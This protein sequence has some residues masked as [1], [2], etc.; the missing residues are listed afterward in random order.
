MT[1]RISSLIILLLI[2]VKVSCAESFGLRFYAHE[3]RLDQRTGLNLNPD[4]P[5]KIKSNFNL[6]FELAFMQDKRDYFGYILRVIADDSLNYDLIYD[7]HKKSISLI[8]GKT[9]KVVSVPLKIKDLAPYKKIVIG[10]NKDQGII[11]LIIDGEQYT[12]NSETL[13][14]NHRWKFLFGINHS[15]KFKTTDLPSMQIRNISLNV[16]GQKKHEWLLNNQTGNWIKDEVGNYDAYVENPDWL[17]D[18]HDTWVLEKEFSFD[19]YTPFVQKGNSDTVFFLSNNTLYTYFLPEHRF[20]NTESLK[21]DI[22]LAQGMQLQYNYVED[23]ILQYSVDNKIVTS[24]SVK[25]LQ[26]SAVINESER[27]TAFWHHNKFFNPNDTTL[28]TLGGYGYLTYKNLIY[29]VNLNNGNWNVNS[30]EKTE[31]MPHYLSALGAN[32]TKDTLYIL[33]GYGSLTGD[34]KINPGYIYDLVQ[35]IPESKKV[36]KVFTIDNSK[37]ESFCLSNSMI[38]DHE[39]SDYYALAY[40]KYE[41]ENYLKLIKGSLDD[42]NIVIDDKSIPFNFHDIMSYVDLIYSPLQRKLYAFILFYNDNGKTNIKVYSISFHPALQPPAEEI[43]RT[44]NNVYL[45]I[46]AITLF[47]LIFAGLIFIFYRRKRNSKNQKDIP[48]HEG[49]VVN[50]NEGASIHEK[51]DER[52]QVNNP[53][54]PETSEKEIII[55]KKNYS[56]SFF[57]GFQVITKNGENITK[58]FTPLLKELFL[59]IYLKSFGNTDRGIS[60]AKLKEILWYDKT[61][62][63]ARNNRAVNIARLKDLL[64]KVG[65]IDISKSTGYWVMSIEDDSLGFDYNN[66]LKISEKKSPTK[67]DIL[68]FIHFT[69]KGEF[70]QNLSYE[71]L[72]KYKAEVAENIIDTLINYANQNKN[73]LDTAFLIQMA[74]IVLLFDSVNEEAL[75]IKCKSLIKCGKHTLA[76]K[77]YDNFIKEYKLLYA[78]DY[79]VSFNRLIEQ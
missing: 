17:F 7:M 31:F 5:Y 58:K 22:L 53:Q 44:N 34:Q 21:K 10:F 2:V 1:I 55:P 27:L 78:E 79:G 13:K 60:S 74:D 49:N 68:E 64:K 30:P 12:L 63:D 8:A 69:K 29:T 19:S 40:S 43:T 41:F 77:N 9:S 14:A 15:R 61:D 33:G 50:N 48:I 23:Q 54:E 18:S 72:D 38:I 70:L 76:K 47:I 35:Y 62:K 51:S 45:F 11:T 28:I 6:T 3:K 32:K 59:L 46:G 24:I 36:S 73:D 42:P 56:I 75:E 16:N 37:I 65:S 4:K 71:W 57:G 66:Y 67:E 20:I 26:P 52:K 39:N 25:T